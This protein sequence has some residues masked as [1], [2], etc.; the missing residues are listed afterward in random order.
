MLEQNNT[1]I[2]KESKKG[3]EKQLKRNIKKCF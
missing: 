3:N 2:K 1:D